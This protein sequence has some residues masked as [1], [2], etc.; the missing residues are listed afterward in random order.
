MAPWM[1]KSVALSRTAVLMLLACGFPP[2]MLPGCNMFAPHPST[3]LVPAWAAGIHVKER[4]EFQMLLRL[5]LLDYIAQNAEGTNDV[6]VG[7]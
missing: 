5:H 6:R 1:L 3:D 4:C 7:P 2:I